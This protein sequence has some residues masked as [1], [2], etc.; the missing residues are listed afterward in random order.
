MW[1]MMWTLS[2]SLSAWSSCSTNHF[3]WPAGSV[4]LIS[5]QLHNRRGGGG[6]WGQRGE[7]G[8][9]EKGSEVME[10]QRE[11]RES[12]KGDIQIHCSSLE[13]WLVFSLVS[14]VGKVCL[15][16][17]DP[18]SLTNSHIVESSTETMEMNTLSTV[19]HI[20]FAKEKNIP[21]KLRQLWFVCITCA[22]GSVSSISMVTYLC[23]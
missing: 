1:P 14:T 10:K 4:L 7:G 12:E 21:K 19:I 2:P 6:K 3:N 5:N 8:A 9:G 13:L 22:R 20:S 17:D 18:Q 16:W 11:K 23:V 15:Q